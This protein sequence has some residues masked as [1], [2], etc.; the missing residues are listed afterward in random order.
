LEA[1]ELADGKLP[2]A[3]LVTSTLLGPLSPLRMS[4]KQGS[5]AG[6]HTR[7]APTSTKASELK[8]KSQPKQIGAD[9][10]RKQASQSTADE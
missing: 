1:A 5:R 9:E 7:Q 2:D 10:P 3:T 8:W 6:Q 4:D